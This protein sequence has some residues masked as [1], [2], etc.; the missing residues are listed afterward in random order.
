M[1]PPVGDPVNVGRPVTD[2]K[3]EE[4][5][6]AP[7]KATVTV[8]A[9]DPTLLLNARMEM[10]VRV[11]PVIVSWAAPAAAANVLMVAVVEAAADTGF[12]SPVTVHETAT[13]FRTVPVT[14]I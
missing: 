12:V 13:L 6:L 1:Q 8:V 2:I 3:A 10:A 14:V 5:A 9:A 4:P 11:T 7:V